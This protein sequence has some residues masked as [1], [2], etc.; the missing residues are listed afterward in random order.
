MRKGQISNL[1]TRSENPVELWG[2]TGGVA[3][4]KSAAA[5]FFAELGIAVID[6]DQIVRELSAPAGA[7]YN[8][9]LQRFGTADRKA[10]R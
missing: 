5:R 7:G 3:S 1:S 8:L 4:G 6:A 2:L 10:L 9:L